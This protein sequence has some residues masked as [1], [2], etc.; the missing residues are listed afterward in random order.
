MSRV[1]V[2]QEGKEGEPTGTIVLLCLPKIE[3]Y[4]FS[5]QASQLR[6]EASPLLC[7]LGQTPDPTPL[8]ALVLSL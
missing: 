4:F 7:D 1:G 6:R 3:P 8:W 2:Y 5:S